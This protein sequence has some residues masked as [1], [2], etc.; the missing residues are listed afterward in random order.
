MS[1][2]SALAFPDVLVLAW[3]SSTSER[4]VNPITSSDDLRR[5]MSKVFQGI[6]GAFTSGGIT[7]HEGCLFLG[8]YG[9][10]E[11]FSKAALSFLA[12]LDCE[13]LA[14]PP[15]EAGI[16]FFISADTEIYT[17]ARAQLDIPVP[18]FSFFSCAFSLLRF[19]FLPEPFRAI[20]WKTIA[21]ARRL[22]Q[23]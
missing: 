9:N 11:A 10:L 14:A 8:L 13:E 20:T 21:R 3:G 6:S 7:A 5:R 4:P 19:D 12:S 18:S 15:F 17:Q 1:D 23:A 16:G 22:K 2:A